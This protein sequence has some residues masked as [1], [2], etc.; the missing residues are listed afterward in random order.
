MSD[1]CE[2]H[3]TTTP[4][5]RAS[6]AP[7]R[8]AS[9]ADIRS[10]LFGK[11]LQPIGVFAAAL[12]SGERAVRS[13]THQDPPLPHYRIGGRIWVDVPKARAWLLERGAPEVP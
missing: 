2:L 7:D 6:A 3:A 1:Q 13:F 11:D 10:E 9:I 12:G 8:A 5:E 4:G